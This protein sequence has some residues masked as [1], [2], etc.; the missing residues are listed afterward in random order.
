MSETLFG[1]IS[2]AVCAMICVAVG[3]NGA[4]VSSARS[5]D[6]PVANFQ[7]VSFSL[8]RLQENANQYSLVI[9]DAEERTNSGLYTV[10][11]LQVLRAIMTEAEKFALNADGVGV[12]E[13][14]T[15]RFADK[16]EKSFIVDVEKGGNQSLLFLT[17]KTDIGRV[18][19]NAGRVIRSSRREEGFFFDLLSR[20]E[21]VLPKL[22]AQPGK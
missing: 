2:A 10:D 18:T 6:R 22:H 3:A 1:K 20:L 11:Q 12:K 8:T 16:S 7:D 17:I 13:P 15:T 5:Q 4:R 9:S 19:V 21:S 14:I